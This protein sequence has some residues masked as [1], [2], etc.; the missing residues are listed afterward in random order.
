MMKISPNPAL[1]QVP[2]AL[3]REPAGNL[4]ANDLPDLE[5]GPVLPQEVFGVLPVPLPAS[6]VDLVRLAAVMTAHQW[7]VQLEPSQM[8]RISVLPPPVVVAA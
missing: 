1:Q 2:V 3:G 5:L 8:A 7:F 6:V 4:M